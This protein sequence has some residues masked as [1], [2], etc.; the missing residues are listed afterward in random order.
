MLH[1]NA[2]VVGI[3]G[4]VRVHDETE[5]NSISVASFRHQDATR[6]SSGVPTYHKSSEYSA[7]GGS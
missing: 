2:S 6:F 1:G 7:Q 5:L 3:P 4:K